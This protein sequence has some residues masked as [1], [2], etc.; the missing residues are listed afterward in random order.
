[1]KM[2][3]RSV[4]IGL[5]AAGIGSG[6]L[7]ASGAF[8]SVE[9]DREVELS[10]TGDAEAL[11]KME[12]GE[13]GENV[14]GTT[15]GDV[16]MIR[17]EQDALNENAT[18]TFAEALDVT[19]LGSRVVELYVEGKDNVGDGEVLDLQ[20][21]GD[22]IVGDITD[23]VTLDPDE[24]E[25]HATLAIVVDLRGNGNDSEDLDAIEEITFV[26]EVDD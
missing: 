3:R 20:A 16:E 11:L 9:A 15:G 8:T 13:H 5:G 4:L 17:L 25:P 6:A 21:D 23:G 26:A 2:N 14:V 18:T 7:F 12:Q 10:V 1:M 22:S 24:G 19:N